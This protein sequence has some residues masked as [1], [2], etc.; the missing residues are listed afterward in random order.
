MY[1]QQ[2]DDAVQRFVNDYHNVIF[3]AKLNL[4]GLFE[5]ED[6]PEASEIRN[7]FSF[8][9][10][11]NPVPASD[12]FRVS[13]GADEVDAIKLDLQ[14]RIEEAQEAANRDLWHRLYDVVSHM[15]ERLSDPEAIFRDSL[16]EN[17]VQMTELLPRLNLN[18]DPQLDAMRRKIEESLCGYSPDELRKDKTLRR[19]AVYDAKDVLD[20]MNGYMVAA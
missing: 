7:K 10:I 1:K 16:M 17:I 18:D 9:T 11:I 6:Y 3:S 8:Q 14:K 4:G 19:K 20:A 15:L 12:D 5:K 2:F 13:L